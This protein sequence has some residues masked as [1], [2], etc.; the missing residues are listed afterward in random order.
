MVNTCSTNIGSAC[1]V[2]DTTQNVVNVG[3]IDKKPDRIFVIC[4]IIVVVLGYLIIKW[5]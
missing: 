4:M 5:G 1:P 3:T 2:I